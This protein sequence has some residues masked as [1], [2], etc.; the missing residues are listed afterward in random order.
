MHLFRLLFLPIGGIEDRG[1]WKND[2]R[3]AITPLLERPTGL[4]RRALI[5]TRKEQVRGEVIEPELHLPRGY[6]VRIARKR[7]QERAI[8]ALLSIPFPY[9]SASADEFILLEPHVE[10]LRRFGIPF[11][12]VTAPV[13]NNG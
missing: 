4:S 8:L 3:A 5:V 2:S 13:E 11:E 10:A 6:V 12:D 9:S 7:D 1:G